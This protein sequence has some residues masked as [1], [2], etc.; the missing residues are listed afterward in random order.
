MFYD[1]R[2][3]NR[4]KCCSWEFAYK[5]CSKII[6]SLKT[7]QVLSNFQC[8]RRLFEEKDMKQGYNGLKYFCTI[9]AVCSRTAYSLDG[10]LSWKVM[11]GIFS[12][13]AAIYGTYWDL[14]MDWGLLQFKSK[15]W[16]LRDKLLIP[17]R[18][19]YFGAMVSKN[20]A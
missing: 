13:T 3:K 6:T 15:N 10:G 2:M 9:V 8:L 1:S 16:L 12:V 5:R 18:S 14:V 19:V 4:T 11:A 20:N 7:R 17:Y